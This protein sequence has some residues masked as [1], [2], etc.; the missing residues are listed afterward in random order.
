[1]YIYVCVCVF[2]WRPQSIFFLGSLSEDVEVFLFS[3][4]VLVE[5]VNK[6][7]HTSPRTFDHFTGRPQELFIAVKFY[8][9]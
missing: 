4:Y 2:C 3:F 8:I 1:M 5:V 9:Y 6:V 7:A